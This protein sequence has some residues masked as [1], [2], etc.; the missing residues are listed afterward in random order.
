MDE[1]ANNLPEL[2]VE[3]AL[4]CAQIDRLYESYCRSKRNDFDKASEYTKTT[5]AVLGAAKTKCILEFE[6]AD[7]LLTAVEESIKFLRGNGTKLSQ[8]KRLPVSKLR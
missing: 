6:N 8:P 4:Y 1:C 3:A 7:R 2:G 5:K